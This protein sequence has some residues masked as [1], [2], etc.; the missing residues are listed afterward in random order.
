LQT[1]CGPTGW[2]Y[3]DEEGANGWLSE[4]GAPTGSKVVELL[5]PNTAITLQKV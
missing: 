3:S 2:W 1:E 4:I 5:I